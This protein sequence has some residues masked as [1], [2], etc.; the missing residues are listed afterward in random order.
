MKFFLSGVY[1]AFSEYERR[2]G[3]RVQ[4][5]ARRPLYGSLDPSSQTNPGNVRRPLTTRWVTAWARWG[6]P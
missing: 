5:S 3:L 1:S 2:T 6:D 4:R